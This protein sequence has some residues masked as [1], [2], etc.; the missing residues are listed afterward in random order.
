LTTLILP[1]INGGQRLLEPRGGVTCRR[2]ARVAVHHE[3]EGSD[4]GV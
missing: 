4:R 1:V 3:T 2:R